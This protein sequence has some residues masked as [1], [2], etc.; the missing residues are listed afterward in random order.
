ME[1]GLFSFILA[2]LSFI[3]TFICFIIYY[4]YRSAGNIALVISNVAALPAMY[5]TI[6]TK[7]L[8]ITA[9]IFG[10]M[11]WSILYHICD[12]RLISCI[13]DTYNSFQ[14]MDFVNSIA[15][16]SLMT[17]YISFHNIDRDNS[18]GRFV[19]NFLLMLE[20]YLNYIKAIAA[21]YIIMIIIGPA[22][23]LLIAQTIYDRCVNNSWPN[24]S[25]ID[26]FIS[27]I[28]VILSLIFQFVLAPLVNYPIFHSL[29]H[30]TI[31]LSVFF[32]YNMHLVN[33]IVR[34]CRRMRDRRSI[35][36]DIE[37]N[38]VN[39]VEIIIETN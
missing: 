22:F 6:Y 20:I 38:D 23:L 21:H 12:S 29:W 39:N 3:P 18:A 10:S 1:H 13:S 26:G 31:Y 17:L 24:L 11:V 19:Y 8:G 33:R 32:V 27:I 37:M 5:L 4:W 35:Q 15:L 7:S 36:N 28:L 9:I 34:C 25:L 30:L 16:V 2:M 14:F